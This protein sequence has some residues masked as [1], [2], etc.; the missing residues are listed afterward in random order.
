M[1]FTCFNPGM[2]SLTEIRRRN[3]KA[4]VSTNGQATVAHR[5]QKPASQI[6]DM[7]A[8]RKSF[9]EK[10]ARSLELAWDPSRSP[11]WLDL[12]DEGDVAQALNPPEKIARTDWPFTRIRQDDVRALS[13]DDRSM[14]EGALALAIAQVGLK[15]P[16][17]GALDVSRRDQAAA[18]IRE[19]STT[20]ANDADYIAIRKV[21]VKIAAGIAGFAA[22]QQR[23]DG[24][25]ESLYL[26]RQWVEKHRYRW[27]ALLATTVKRESESMLP[28]IKP[29]DIIVF[30][31]DDTTHRAEEVFAVNHEG[32]FTLKR[33]KKRLGHWWLYSDNEDQKRYP[34][35]M[36]TDLTFIIGK[37]VLMQSDQL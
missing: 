23:D 14:V 28:R 31:T 26:A 25:G 19:A 12:S 35:V 13:P 5:V 27:Q 32:E 17:A 18:I 33:L 8:G 34:P 24:M 9:G 1:V 10:V 29:G 3:L 11:G 15:M 37:I 20:A 22:E 36:C 4:L 7:I 30:N 2:S 21:A 6:N 16:V